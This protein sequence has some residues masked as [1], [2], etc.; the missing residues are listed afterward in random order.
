MPRKEVLQHD[1]GEDEEEGG[2]VSEQHLV[3]ATEFNDEKKVRRHVPKHCH[4]T[5]QDL[6]SPN[7]FV[8]FNADISKN[9]EVQNSVS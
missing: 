5:S 2:E 7:I 1:E 3:V 4:T 8:V 6:S 9:V